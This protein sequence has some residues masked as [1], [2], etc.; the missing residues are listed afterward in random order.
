[1][2][3]C[4]GEARGQ[5][6]PVAALGAAE[7]ASEPAERQPGICEFFFFPFFFLLKYYSQFCFFLYILLFRG[8]FLF[9]VFFW[10]L[11]FECGHFRKANEWLAQRYG[12]D[13]EIDWNLG[14]EP[15]AVEPAKEKAVNKAP[16][17][18]APAQAA[19]AAAAS[20]PAVAASAAEA[21]VADAA[22]SAATTDPSSVTTTAAAD[23]D[24]DGS[25]AV[26]TVK[27]AELAEPELEPKLDQADTTADD[28]KDGKDN[29]DTK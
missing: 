9:T 17:A 29:K 6:E 21:A 1:M 13:G 27:P 23:D 28:G 12:P 3:Q 16:P 26:E 7:R 15:A 18:A 4:G 19:A 25:H 5:G 22:G 14:D 8:L 10:K 11:Q 24:D 20:P 2:G